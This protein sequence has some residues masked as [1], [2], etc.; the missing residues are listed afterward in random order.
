MTGASEDELLGCFWLGVEAGETGGGAE[1]SD[2]LVVK[3]G[4]FGEEVGGGV[5][6]E[7]AATAGGGVHLAPP[8]LCLLQLLESIDAEA[9]E[10]DLVPAGPASGVWR[11]AVGGSRWVDVGSV[12][13]R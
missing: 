10:G 5:G 6:A 13:E 1:G 7:I 11:A 2:S 3:G 4:A 8:G 12:V 9:V